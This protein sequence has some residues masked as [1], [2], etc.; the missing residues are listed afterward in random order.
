G[1]MDRE[2]GAAE[3]CAFVKRLDFAPSA[4][5]FDAAFASDDAT[6]DI[7]GYVERA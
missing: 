7:Q 6:K 4:L 1:K 2:H 5:A 3:S